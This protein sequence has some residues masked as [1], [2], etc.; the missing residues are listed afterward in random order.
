M[1]LTTSTLT[2]KKKVLFVMGTTGTGKTKLSINL[3]T[4]FPSE[5]INSDKI[6]V[7]KGL[8]IVT[9]K[10]Q[11]SERCSI[12][13]HILGIIDDPD[14]DFTMDD[15]CK[16]VLEALDLITQ[17][18]HLPIIV[19]GSNSYLKKLL[20]DPT[21]AFHSKYDCSFIWLDVSLPILFPYLDK[22]V[23][24]MVAVGMVDEIRDFFVPGADNTKGIRRAIGVP[25]LD[26]YFEMEMKK[27]V[28]D[29]QKEKIL[30]ESIRKTKQNTFILA[31]NQLSKIQNMAAKFGSMINKIDSTEVFEAILRGE[32]Y[33]HLHQ[34][35]VIK[36]SMKIVKRFLEGTSH[37]F[38]KAK[39]SNGNGKHTPNG[40]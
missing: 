37:G 40:V 15:F 31:E 30:Q 38:R 36:P 7:Y 21:I 16:H 12:P 1:A 24:E 11:K 23:D 35:I 18:G 14:Y 3:G 8:D 26:S 4:Q 2:N 29:A 10:V 32:D 20:E 9:N 17:N 22:R 25:E 33:Q 19:G 34:E 13:H 5:I 28:D 39:H 6:Q 27:G